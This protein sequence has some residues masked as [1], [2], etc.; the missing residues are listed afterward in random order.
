MTKLSDN[1]PPPN[2]RER[3]EEARTIAEHMID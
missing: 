1:D 2:W 3:A